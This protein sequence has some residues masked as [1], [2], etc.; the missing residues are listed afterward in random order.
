MFGLFLFLK[1]RSV[2]DVG[3]VLI[4]GNLLTAPK[5]IG[6]PIEWPWAAMT[7]RK[8]NLR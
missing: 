1:R 5:N 3:A 8:V 2:L 4:L 7:L 6:I